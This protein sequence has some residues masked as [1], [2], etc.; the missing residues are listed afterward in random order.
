[1]WSLPLTAHNQHG[2][3]QQESYRQQYHI[4]LSKPQMFCLVSG[5]FLRSRVPAPITPDKLIN[6]RGFFLAENTYFT[7]KQ[8]Q[9]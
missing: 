8:Q 3:T 9:Q 7:I 1:M 6:L 4:H 2:V 5:T